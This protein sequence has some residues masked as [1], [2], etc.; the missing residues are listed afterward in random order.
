VSLCIIQLYILQ[1][2]KITFHLFSVIKPNGVTFV[3]AAGCVG[4]AVKAYTALHYLGRLISGDTGEVTLMT[5]KIRLMVQVVTWCGILHG[6]H[7]LRGTWYF[8]L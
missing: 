2:L 6:C 5:R 4:D 1:I 3:D 7:H 8:C